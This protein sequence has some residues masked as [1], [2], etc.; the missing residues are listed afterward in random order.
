[1]HDNGTCKEN[2]FAQCR[3]ILWPNTFFKSEVGTVR[4]LRIRILFASTGIISV[5][6][7]HFDIKSTYQIRME[8]KMPELGV[9]F[10]QPCPSAAHRFAAVKIKFE[11]LQTTRSFP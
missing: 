3:Q 8:K 7:L 4:I 1:V 10:P 11:S 6:A 2:A 5:S 9:S